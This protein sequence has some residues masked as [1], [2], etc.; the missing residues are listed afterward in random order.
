MSGLTH[1]PALPVASANMLTILRKSGVRVPRRQE[2]FG[3]S[4]RK[5]ALVCHAIGDLFRY[6]PLQVSMRVADVVG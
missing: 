3:M 1:Q 2:N 6:P 5:R 4:S